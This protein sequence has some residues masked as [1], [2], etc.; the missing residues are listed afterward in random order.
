M[1]EVF[2]CNREKLEKIDLIHSFLLS[3]PKKMEMGKTS[4]PMVFNYEA[5]APEENGI[6]GVIKNGHAHISVHT[7]PENNKAYVN[8]FSSKQVDTSTWRQELLNYFE[9]SDFKEEI[10]APKLFEE[11]LPALAGSL[12]N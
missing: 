12:R 4:E 6:S 2:N 7:F 10:I 11:E 1:L 3:L 5:E 8:L 9:T